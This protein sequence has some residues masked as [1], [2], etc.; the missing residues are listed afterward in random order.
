MV[1]HELDSS[2]LNLHSGNT[3]WSLWSGM[4]WFGLCQA[5]VSWSIKT[6]GQRGNTWINVT[7]YFGGEKTEPMLIVVTMYTHGR[8]PSATEVSLHLLPCP[9]LNWGH[10]SPIFFP[11]SIKKKKGKKERNPKG[12]YIQFLQDPPSTH[13]IPVVS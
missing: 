2:D 4:K 7:S 13:S 3:Y 6:M 8:T 1:K 12:I 5:L 9:L 10:G 11:I